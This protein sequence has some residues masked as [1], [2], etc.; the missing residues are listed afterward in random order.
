LAVAVPRLPM[1][2]RLGRYLGVGPER[3][4]LWPLAVVTTVLAAASAL[5]MAAMFHPSFDPSRI[6]DGTDT[7]AFGLLFGAALAMVWPS[8]SLRAGV[9]RGARRLLGVAGWSGLAV[10]AVLMVATNEYS[11]F[12]YRGGMVLLSLAT[13]L[14]VASVAHPA[15][16]L[17]RLLGCPPLRWVGVRSYGIYVWHY[18]V[19][20]LTSPAATSGTDVLRAAAQV[21]ATLALADLSWR[22]VESPVRHGA[23]GRLWAQ[24]RAPRRR[25]A[26]SGRAW[27]ALSS[28]PVAMVVAVLA[29]AGIMPTVPE[30]TLA[31]ST[32]LPGGTVAGP[33]DLA[34]TVATTVATVATTVA[35][36]AA[37]TTAAPTTAAPT[38]AAPT[39][40]GRARPGPSG[41]SPASRLTKPAP[42][43]PGTRGPVTGTTS[44]SR[45][46]PARTGAT[47]RTTLAPA[48]AKPAT[49][50]KAGGHAAKTGATGHATRTRATGHATA[51]SLATRTSLVPATSR[52]GTTRPPAA[53]GTAPATTV[54][55]AP[56]LRTSCQQ[57]A[58]FGDST[59]ESLV[60][61]QYLPDPAQRLNAQYSRVGAQNSI[62]RIVGGTSIVETLPGDQNATQMAQQLVRQGFKGCWVLA[63]GTNDTAD[64]Y[65]G[66]N[67]GM[68]ARIK[69]MMSV[70]GDQ[71]VLWV[72]VRTLVTSGP[73]A[74]ANM[75]RWDA[76][77]LA[78]CPSYPN[79][80]I[81]NWAGV[82]K[83]S[84]F[85]ADGIHY[86]SPGSAPRAAAIAD[87]LATAFPADARTL[88]SAKA[89]GKS[90]GGNAGCMV[91]EASSWHLPTF[92][93]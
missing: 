77:L 78:A 75:E 80:R 46:G 5:E 87:A 65:V 39:T 17:G 57:V 45:P 30:G 42:G 12:L 64:V 1:G 91:N 63:L 48:H 83:P 92:K 10:M 59:S 70:I 40:A 35:T 56:A 50:T 74:E 33:G 26:L 90:G 18:P 89:K 15:S 3:R 16:R 44:A 6:Y 8:R 93:D 79:M 7:R 55:A 14:V 2:E 34:G 20:V 66:S 86:N 47:T 31:A 32:S 24:V 84:W 71:P 21:V 4:R 88:A 54:P 37:P 60:S 27:V 69:Q 51:T 76:A 9:E 25:A 53:R 81:F 28:V 11:G 61:P 85:I 38:T 82:A 13:V 62:M 43:A 36:T 19:I 58:H 22:F 41:G 68:A 49:K 23:I 29:L 52:P 72:N 67:V 73:Y